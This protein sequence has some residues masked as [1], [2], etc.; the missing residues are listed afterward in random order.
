MLAS[1]SGALP[2]LAWNPGRLLP[3][4]AVQARLPSH[5]WALDPLF[6]FGF[7]VKGLGRRM[8]CVQRVRVTGGEQ[9]QETERNRSRQRERAHSGVRV[10]EGG[11]KRSE[12]SE[13]RRTLPPQT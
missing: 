9:E 10:S 6:H 5:P 12:K 8:A 4:P 13:T 2:M 1:R 3:C 11:G 7:R